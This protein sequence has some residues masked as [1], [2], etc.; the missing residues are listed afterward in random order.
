MRS[1]AG[2]GARTGGRKRHRPPTGAFGPL[3]RADAPITRAQRAAHQ[4]VERARRRLPRAPVATPPIIRHP[5][6]TQAAAARKLIASSITRAVGSAGTG[7]ERLQRR[8]ALEQEILS[9][10]RYRRARAAIAH[11]AKA[12]A[13]HA[14]VQIAKAYGAR[15][16]RRHLVRAGQVLLASRNARDRVRPGIAPT[17]I[18]VA[19]VGITPRDI[20]RTVMGVTSLAGGSAENTITKRAI[21]DLGTL[22]TGPFVGGYE[23]AKAAGSDLA[24]GRTILS[25]DS[26]LRKFGGAVAGSIAH[27]VTHP[28]EAFS[29][30]PLLTTLDLFGALSVAGRVAGATSRMATGGRVGG[31]VRSPIAAGPDG[32]GLIERRYSKDIIRKQAERVADALREPVR[33]SRGQ[34]VTVEQR[35]HRVPVLQAHGHERERFQQR[36]A[37]FDA[38]RANAAERFVRDVAGAESHVARRGASGIKGRGARDIV[39]MVVE[40]T[41]RTERTFVKDLERER[42]RIRSRLDEHERTGDVYRDTADLKAAQQRLGLVEKVLTSPKALSQ[43]KRIV[44]AGIEHAKRLNE[45]ERE[46]IR[47]GLLDERQATRRRLFPVAMSHGDARHFTVEEH[48]RLERTALQREQGIRQALEDAAT[49]A[50]RA[51]LRGELRQAREDRIAVSGREPARVHAHE[52][53]RARAAAARRRERQAAAE[54][55]RLQQQRAR[56]VGGQAVRRG[57]EAQRGP[58]RAYYVGDRRF[59]TRREAEAWRTRHT[60][61]PR[62]RVVARTSGEARRTGELA[63]IDKR[64]AQRREERAQALKDA[65]LADQHVREH[66]MPKIQAGLRSSDG[67]FLSNKDIEKLLDGRDPNTV[68]YLPHRQDVRGARSHHA[69]FRPGTRPN[70]AKEASTGEAYRKGATESS[71]EVLHDAGVRQAVQIQKARAIDRSVADHGV[72]HPAWA[73]AQRGEALTAQE[74]RVVDRGGYFTAREAEEYAN[75]IENDTGERFVPVK[76]FGWQL[77]EDAKRVIRDDLQGPAGLDTLTQRM[78]N[79]RVVPAGDMS[80]ARNVVLMPAAYIERLERHLRPANELEKFFQILNRPFRFAVL[81][82]LRWLV[83]NIIEPFFVRLPMVGSGAIN[84]FGMA[85]D[86]RAANRV[87]RRM[88]RSGDPRLRAAAI[89]IRGQQLGGTFIGGRGAS[90]RRSFEELPLA[91][92]A[93]GKMLAKLPV[94]T[95]GIDLLR[96]AGRALMAPGNLYFRVN[97]AIEALAQRNA[98]GRDIRRDLEEFTGSWAKTLKL[99][100]DALDEVARG[101][102]NTPTQQRLMRSQ[103]E[104]L[105]K[106]EGF[107]PWMRRLTQTIMPFLPWA[108][109]AARFVYWTVPVHRTAQA[110]LLIKVNDVVSKDWKE[111]H[112]DTPPGTLRLA[113]PTAKGGWIDLARYTPFGLSGQLTEGDTGGLLD[114][115]AP[116]LQGAYKALGGKDPFGRDLRIDPA[117][118]AGNTTPNLGQ[119]AGIAAYGLGEALVPY[120]SQLRR[121][122]E[123]GGTPYAGSTVFDPDVKPGTDYMSGLRRTFDPFRPTYLNPPSRPVPAAGPGRRAALDQQDRIDRAL[124]RITQLDD[125]SVAQDERINKALDA[126]GIP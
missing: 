31:T 40:G 104:L 11:Y 68:A 30:H 50:E 65:R 97:R 125:Q 117:E 57:Q 28:G 58:V 29:Q 93:Y 36:A 123:G 15:G 10:P 94:V 23:L 34:V 32:T 87:L 3:E 27:E 59:E 78:L 17:R 42:D 124:E 14:A 41:I 61:S 26:Q 91:S 8:Q 96:L 46:A 108:L 72:R 115:V 95:Q 54:I 107:A 111:L 126:I 38:S 53:A 99:H 55:A 80:R 62:V 118:N 5:T 82:Q 20:G 56:M 7:R 106:Y 2:G 37:D 69:Q 74:R 89:E 110:T 19:G 98:L 13:D 85:L 63:Q 48:A 83:G 112:A 39:S 51:R 114:Q 86:V 70:L 103:H 71:A 105:G 75:R 16:T 76:A 44:D 79:D 101:L 52:T 4:R 25:G 43:A 1:P 121:V 81:A 92:S 73:K 90:V 64:I 18:Q 6:P 12:E 88:E 47:L 9:D 84:V 77:S 100:Q 116:Q 60:G 49:P 102:V 113:I 66:P 33:D 35:G 122:R 24:H 109:N 119:R 21:A 22:G 67:R 120:V 45:R